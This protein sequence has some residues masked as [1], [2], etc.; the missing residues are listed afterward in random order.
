MWKS[1]TCLVAKPPFTK[2]LVVVVVVVVVVVMISIISIP[3]CELPIALGA[4]ARARRP[5]RVPEPLQR[6]VVFIQDQI[7]LQYNTCYIYTYMCVYI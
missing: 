6:S 4:R 3:L 5:A 2:T 7:M 1:K